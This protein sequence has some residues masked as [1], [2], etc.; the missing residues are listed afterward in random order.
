MANGTLLP[1]FPVLKLVWPITPCSRDCV[2]PLCV[3]PRPETT[4]F[5]AGENRLLSSSTEA[6]SD[7]NL[8]GFRYDDENQREIGRQRGEM[9]CQHRDM[10]RQPR[11][12]D[13]QQKDI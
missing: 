4:E 10:D 7:D 9:E 13:C 11:Q 1:R 5:D 8:G 12:M 3:A 2:S 6:A